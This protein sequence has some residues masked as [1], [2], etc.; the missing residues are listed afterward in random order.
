MT[1]CGAGAVWSRH[2]RRG[3]YEFR[4]MTREH[5][6]RFIQDAYHGEAMPGVIA[7]AAGPTED[8]WWAFDL[9]EDEAAEQAIGA[10]AVKLLRE[11]G[12]PE[13]PTVRT[14][15]VHNALTDVQ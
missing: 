11:L 10:P 12:V 14:F 8:G 6:E 5:Y 7:H 4:G 15:E 2:G 13:D 9:Y 1:Q 3:L